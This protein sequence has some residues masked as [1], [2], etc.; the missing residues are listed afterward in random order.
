MNETKK[1]DILS[2]DSN[3]AEVELLYTPKEHVT[4][5]NLFDVRVSVSVSLALSIEHLTAL[6]FQYF[7]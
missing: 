6:A 4:M 1:N 7:S 3:E 2:S 5:A